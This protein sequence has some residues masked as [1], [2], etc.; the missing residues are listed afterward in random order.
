MAGKTK[1]STSGGKSLKTRRKHRPNDVEFLDAYLDA[2]ESGAELARRLGLSRAA[3]SDRLKRIDP[4]G[5]KRESLRTERAK[6]EGKKGASAVFVPAVMTPSSEQRGRILGRMASL[7]DIVEGILNRLQGEMETHLATPGAKLKPFH[8]ELILK[9]CRQSVL[10]I[11]R[12]HKMRQESLDSA[13]KEDFFR[14]VCDVMATYDPEVQTKI[15][16]RLFTLG[17]PGAAEIISGE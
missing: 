13:A 12:I 11:E 5:T 10:Q 3:V 17:N 14:A 1:P 8:V 2:G 7:C 15:Y 6:S 16:H 9:T 4:E